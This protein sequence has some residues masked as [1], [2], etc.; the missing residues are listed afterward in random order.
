MGLS[1]KISG[2]NVYSA[3]NEFLRI[4][5]LTKEDII[6]EKTKIQNF[7][8]KEFISQDEEN[9]L[10]AKI[11][12]S[13]LPYEKQFISKNGKRICTLDDSVVN[14]VISNISDNKLQKITLKYGVDYFFDKSEEINEL[15]SL[16][17]KLASQL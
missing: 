1:T 14:L 15:I 9:T 17:E 11:N 12:G 8:P 4:L 16:I 3:N 7:I 6:K 5:E 13:C 10:N 2:G